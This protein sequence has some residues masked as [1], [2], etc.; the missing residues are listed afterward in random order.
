MRYKDEEREYESKHKR[1]IAEISE[2]KRMQAPG[3]SGQIVQF[4]KRVL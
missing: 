1:Y 4:L 3:A 2:G